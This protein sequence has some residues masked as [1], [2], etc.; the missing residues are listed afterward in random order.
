MRKIKVALIHN[1]IAPYRHPL[2]ERL[3]RNV[4]LKV[5]Y[6]SVKHSSH[7]WDLWPRVYDYKF[8]ILP[9]ISLRTP[10]TEISV[11]PSIVKEIIRDR[12]HVIILSGYI[13]P[14]MWLAFGI[15]T[16]LKIPIVYWTEGVREPQSFLGLLTRP[17]RMFFIK[18]AKAIIVPGRLSRN[19]VVSMGAKKSKVFIAANSINND[20]FIGLS[21]KYK[22]NKERLKKELGVN[23]EKVVLYVGQLIERKAV[24]YLLRAYGRLK[25]EHGEV[26]L[27]IVGSGPLK[28]QLKYICNANAISDVHFI[29]SGLRIIDLIEYYSISDVFVLPTRM[30]VWG[31]V[32]NEAMACGLTVIST[33]NA[34]AAIEMIRQGENGFVI[35]DVDEEE[36]YSTM[37]KLL[38][39]EELE[40]M[41]K[42]S[43]E[44]VTRG[45]DPSLMKERFIAAISYALSIS[46]ERRKA[47]DN[48]R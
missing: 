6:C 11:N 10:T 12:P 32:I 31:F 26:A 2:F 42:K 33:K 3:S 27:V 7:K 39:R 9:K 15:G 34:Q 43:L 45:F 18:E 37:N 16:I 4:D 14:T 13:Y 36:L 23:K 47:I 20:F 19:Y 41:G 46:F 44:T 24:D 5:Y 21:S 17:M 35:N 30:D 40:S 1:T 8:K 22:K 48:F 38:S 28:D 29:E 25:Q